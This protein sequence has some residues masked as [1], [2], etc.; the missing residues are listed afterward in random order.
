MFRVVLLIQLP[1]VTW[2]LSDLDHDKL[3]TLFVCGQGRGFDSRLRSE[4]GAGRC[5][6]CDHT[7]L[8]FLCPDSR[9]EAYMTRANCCLVWSH[10]LSW[11]PRHTCFRMTHTSECQ[12]V[13]RRW[14][15][16]L[17]Y[18][19]VPA[20]HHSPQKDDLAYLLLEPTYERIRHVSPV[21]LP[22]LPSHALHAHPHCWHSLPLLHPLP[23]SHPHLILQLPHLEGGGVSICTFVPLKQVNWIPAPAESPWVV[24]S[25]SLTSAYGRL[26][27]PKGP[28]HARDITIE[29]DHT[30]LPS[31]IR[32]HTSAYEVSGAN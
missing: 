22:A 31:G 17:L 2:L 1:P 26:S 16:V 9:T 30:H 29:V 27:S 32:Q 25:D 7:L 24:C 20:Q 23:L 4:P 11:T 10:M 14:R 13:G 5:T 28:G 6:K 12:A 19:P 21:S 8:D 18:H 15:A 3:L